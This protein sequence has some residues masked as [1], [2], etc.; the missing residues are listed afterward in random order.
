MKVIHINS[1][2]RVGSTG[3]NVYE[4]HTAMRKQGIESFVASTHMG[5]NLRKI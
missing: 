3:R 4:L 1:V 2:Y 5:N